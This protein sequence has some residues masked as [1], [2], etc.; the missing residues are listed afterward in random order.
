[1][2][3]DSHLGNKEVSANAFLQAEAVKE[4][5]AETNIKAIKRIKIGSKKVCVREDLAKEKMVF[6]Q[7]S[8]RSVFAM[9]NVELIE[10]KTSLIQCPSCRHYVFKR[11]NYLSMWQAYQTQPGDDT[12]YQN[13]FLKF[14]KH[15]SSV[16]LSWRQEVTN[17]DSTCG[18]NTTSRQKTHYEARERTTELVRRS[19]T[20]GKIMRPIGSTN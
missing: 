20:D 19:W 11:D 13:R 2:D 16:R 17:K 15:P 9:D 18:R 14:S 10:L 6:S 7:E 3:V 12:T 5:I 1:M 4:E 8:S